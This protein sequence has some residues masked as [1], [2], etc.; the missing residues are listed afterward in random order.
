MDAVTVIVVAPTL[1]GA[2][3]KVH[4]TGHRRNRRTI[5]TVKSAD[6]DCCEERASSA[7]VKAKVLT[8]TYELSDA[9]STLTGRLLFPKAIAGQSD[10]E[11]VSQGTAR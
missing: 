4:A 11:P 9:A 3:L 1:D 2:V 10:I 8:Q 6:P 7:K 5:T